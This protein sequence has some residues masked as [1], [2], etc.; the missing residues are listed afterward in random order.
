MFKTLFFS[1][2]AISL[3]AT[4][5]FAS[6]VVP[7]GHFSGVGLRG[8]GH[9][10]L[11]PGSEQR[12]T[13]LKGSTQFTRFHV[14]P[15]GGLQI[16]ACYQSCPEHYDLEVVIVSPEL[17]AIAVEGGGAIVADSGFP[18]QDQLS[19]AVNGGGS[20]DVRQMPAGSV[21][22]AVN[23]GGRI[24]TAPKGALNAAIN[25]GGHI[26]YWGNPQVNEAVRGG[27]VVDRGQ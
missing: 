20:I 26:T 10:V 9:V 6:E 8:G 16:D 25:G 24:K 27:G 15:G 12:V 13:I 23:G 5:V 19:V 7:L 22:A 4:P 1:I 11:R 3:L 21:S 14:E 2:A 18:D 17:D